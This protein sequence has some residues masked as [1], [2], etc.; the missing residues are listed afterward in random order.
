MAMDCKRA[1]V[2]SSTTE[3]LPAQGRVSRSALS[4]IARGLLL[5]ATSLVPAA[6][7]AAETAAPRLFTSVNIIGFATVAGL[8]AFSLIAAYALTRKRTVIENENRE[9][10]TALSDARNRISQYEALIADK[11]RRIVI[12]DGLSG[13]PEFL[14]QLPLETGHP[15]MIVNSSPSGAG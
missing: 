4:P 9:I 13:Q 3:H 6:A 7:C 8:M 2:R 15:S 5:S 14:G 10:R 11:N 12:W 1:Q